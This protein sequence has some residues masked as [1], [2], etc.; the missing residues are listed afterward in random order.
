MLLER[1]AP[2]GTAA[3]GEPDGDSASGASPEPGL[4]DIFESGSAGDNTARSHEASPQPAAEAQGGSAA[5]LSEDIAA[6]AVVSAELG[7]AFLLRRP[8][9]WRVT[10]GMFGRT[11]APAPD[12]LLRLYALEA[13]DNLCRLGRI[14]EKAAPC[15]GAER[16]ASTAHAMQWAVNDTDAAS[17]ALAVEECVL[18]LREVLGALETQT[19]RKESKPS[20]HEGG[21]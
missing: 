21:R 17:A 15:V 6:G 8:E 18:A 12:L 16:L 14:L 9:A 19:A 4:A 11:F 10:A 3:S 5:P 13:A 2:R 20:V 1:T 7:R